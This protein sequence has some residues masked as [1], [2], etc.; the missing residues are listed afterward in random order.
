VAFDILLKDYRPRPELVTET[1]LVN[2][3]LVPVID[4][5]NYISSQFGHP[6]EDRPVKEL[7]DLMDEAG[8][9]VIVDLDGGFGEQYLTKHLDH[10]KRTAP[11]R[12]YVFG[13]V[14]VFQFAEKGNSFGDWAAA[15]F[16]KQCSWGAQGLKV[17]KS[18]GLQA[19]DHTGRLIGVDDHRLDPLWD[20]AAEL[21]LPVVI[22]VGDPAAFFRPMEATNERCE[23][24]QCHPDWHFQLPPLSAAA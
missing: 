8:V 10:F 24:L 2:K 12:F 22:H 1:H 4:G 3:P 21:K 18:L 14:D 20:T 13:G 11:E 9:E 19:K 17:W 7:L 5:H 16:R 6:W 23:E 15:E